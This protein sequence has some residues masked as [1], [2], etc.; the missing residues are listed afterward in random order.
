MKSITIDEKDRIYKLAQ[1]CKGYIQLSKLS[2]ISSSALQSWNKVRKFHFK[3]RFCVICGSP[4]TKSQPE[5]T[6]LC[7]I[8]TMETNKNKFRERK[9]IASG[10]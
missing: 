2:G 3:A 1:T 8:C 4:I 6:T 10:M 5:E 7:Q 9:K